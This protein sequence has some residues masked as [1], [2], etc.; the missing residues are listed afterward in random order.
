MGRRLLETE[1]RLE[2]ALFQD[3]PSRLAALLLQLRTDMGSNDVELTHEQL[4]E[5][6]GVYRETVTAALNS[7]RKEDL[8]SIG[9]KH[10][11]LINLPELERKAFG[12]SG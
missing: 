9:R 3:V 1:E 4:A 7:L 5:H 6:L 10:V 8:V 2:Q 11:H 12:K